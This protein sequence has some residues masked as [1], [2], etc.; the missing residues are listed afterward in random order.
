ME[1]SVLSRFLP[2][3]SRSVQWARPVGL[4]KQRGL[5][6]MQNGVLRVRRRLRPARLIASRLLSWPVE[7]RSSEV[8]S[9]YKHISWQPKRHLIVSIIDGQWG[10][11][12]EWTACS[13]TCDSGT[14][15]R[16]RKCD[17]PPPEPEARDCQ[18][19]DIEKSDCF[20]EPCSGIG[21][22]LNNSILIRCL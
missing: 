3:A 19:A 8:S 13:R 1:D 10:G 4:R 18:G 16:T 9:R 7:R 22:M 6:R 11:W 2:F 20:V 15:Q 14:Q 5:L 12:T 21:A 17:S